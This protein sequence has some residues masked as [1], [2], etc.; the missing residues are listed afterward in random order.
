MKVCRVCQVEKEV[1]DFYPP[2]GRKVCKKCKNSMTIDTSRA[3][4]GNLKYQ[5]ISNYSPD[6][7]CACQNCPLTQPG[8]QFLSIDH[9]DG[10]GDHGREIR[11]RLY[12]W[13]KNNDYPSGFQVLC[14]NCNFAK[15]GDKYCPHNL[16]G[17]K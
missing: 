10:K 13:L 12:Q 2:D 16:K 11:K 9:I 14:Y 7:T 1:D 15:R 4:R 6:L 8:I 5:V 3:F 17:M